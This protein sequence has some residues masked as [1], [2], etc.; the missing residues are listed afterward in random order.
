MAINKVFKSFKEAVA[1]VPAGASIMIGGFGGT[2]GTPQNLI[3]ALRNQGA[4]N[5]TV[6][7]NAPFI[8]EIIGVHMQQKYIDCNILLQNK[9]VSKVIASLPIYP[10]GPRDSLLEIQLAAGEVEL[11]VVPQGTLALRMWA[12]GAGIGGVYTPTGVG[13]IFEQSKGKKV[14]DGKE[15]VLELPLRADYAFVRAYKADKMGNLVYRLASRS[16]NPVIAPAAAITIAEVD[17]IV[18]PGELA[19]DVIIT[20]GIYVNRIV[21]IPKEKKR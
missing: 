14:I 18:E 17:E 4:K 20:S 8:S 2:G 3:L 15:Y 6:I 5:L 13:T 7:G 1:D 16:F 9:Q 19:P 11:E 12:G 10:F 21:E